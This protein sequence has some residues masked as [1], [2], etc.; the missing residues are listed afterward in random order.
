MGMIQ[1]FEGEI[2]QQELDGLIEQVRTR[3][4]VQASVDEIREA[5]ICD[6]EDSDISAVTMQDIVEVIDASGIA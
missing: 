6:Y 4:E 2:D 3:Y 5:V 1:T